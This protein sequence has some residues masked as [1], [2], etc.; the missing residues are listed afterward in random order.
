MLYQQATPAWCGHSSRSLGVEGQ[1]GQA[2]QAVARLEQVLRHHLH[3]GRTGMSSCRRP[4]ANDV[5]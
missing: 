5:R 1:L 2:S 3:I 4:S